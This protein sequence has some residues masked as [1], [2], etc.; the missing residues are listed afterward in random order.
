MERPS[1]T[2]LSSMIGLA[3]QLIKWKNR[4][5]FLKERDLVMKSVEKSQHI[6]S[7]EKLN[8]DELLAIIFHYMA[9]IAAEN[10]LEKLLMH[11]ADLGKE[12]VIADRCTVWLHKPDEKKI[13]TMAAHNMDRIIVAEESGFIGHCVM[14]GE[15][16]IVDD[17]YKDKRFNKQIDLDTGYRTKSVL[18]IPFRNTEGLVI[19]AF[20]AINHMS[21]K[22][23]FKE[24]DVEILSL[25]A[26]YAGKSL[27]SSI[28]RNELIETQREI[29]ETMGEIGESRSQET[30]SHVRRVAEYSYLLA[31]LAGV[32]EDAAKQLK[33]ASPMHDIGK[34]AIPDRILLKP[35]KLTEEEFETMKEHAAIGFNIFK[36]S[37]R[38]LLRT[39]AIIA[40]EHH[41]R[42]DGTGYP[43]GLAGEKISILGRITAIVDVFDALGTARV[44][45]EAWSDERIFDYMIA[46]RGQQF[47]PTLI[48][49]LIT[50]FDQFIKIRTQIS[51]S[52]R[53]LKDEE[54]YPI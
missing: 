48:D 46:Q 42:W 4:L 11:L 32:S 34:V 27:E 37:K 50:N 26:T 41:E 14:T 49:L 2:I 29:I 52:N 38:S 43:N 47:D 31:R 30:G 23:I 35:G 20:Q 36:H 21:S 22:K 12:I 3:Y 39:A 16:V 9:I 53:E 8:P 24:A 13:W 45:K 51:N 18:C 17:A 6:E 5:Y 33:L 54:K 15:T 1:I 40:H 28:L 7:T 44:Y 19:G 25:A 10:N